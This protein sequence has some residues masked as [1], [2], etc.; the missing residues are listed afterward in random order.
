[1]NI[2]VSSHT[3][4]PSLDH[5]KWSCCDSSVLKREKTSNENQEVD[6]RTCWKMNHS[7]LIF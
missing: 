3:H 1:M 6:L 5:G 4:L 7:F 2:F